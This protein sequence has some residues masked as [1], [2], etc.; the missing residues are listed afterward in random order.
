MNKTTPIN[1]RVV[2]PKHTPRYQLL[3]AGQVRETFDTEKG[4]KRAARNTPHATW[5][6]V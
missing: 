2:T 6:E 1:E 4:V 5:R 3:V